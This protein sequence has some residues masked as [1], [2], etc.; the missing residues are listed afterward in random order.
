MSPNSPSSLS[1]G[2]MLSRKQHGDCQQ[3]GASH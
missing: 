1:T 2:F 3:N